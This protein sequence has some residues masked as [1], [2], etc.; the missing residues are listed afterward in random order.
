M[1]AW[2]VASGNK[3]DDGTYTHEG[4]TATVMIMRDTRAGVNIKNG[5]NTT[6]TDP[7]LLLG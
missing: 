5:Y 7:I 3:S 1:W 4:P 6:Q 2:A